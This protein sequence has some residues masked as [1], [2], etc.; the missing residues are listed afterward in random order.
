M[1]AQGPC[2]PDLFP[3]TLNCPTNLTFILQAGLCETTVQLSGVSA[4]DNCDLSVDI[5]QTGGLPINGYFPIGSH[6]V[7]LRATDDA[8]NFS[9]CTFNVVVLE[10]PYP[11][12]SLVCNTLVYLTV[13]QNGTAVVNADMVLEGGPYGCYS[14]YLVSITDAMGLD[15]GNTVTCDEIGDFLIAKV[16]DPVSGNSCWGQIVLEDKTPPIIN[17]QDWTIPCTRAVTTV[18]APGVIDNCDSNP[19]LNL[20]GVT[21][22]ETDACDDNAVRFL[23]TWYATDKF[24]NTS[25]PCLEIITVQRP[26]VVDFPSDIVWQ[27]NQYASRPN[28]TNASPLRSNIIDTIPSTEVIDV[29][30]LFIGNQLNNTGSGIP[31]NI[32]GEFCKYNI[33][34]SDD[35]IAIC[36]N[37]P[38]V[39][40][41]VRTWT[42]IDWCTGNVIIT[43]VDGEDNV[44]VIK[45][46]D[47]VPPV[48]SASNLTVNANIPG[49]HPQPCR[50]TAPFPS[51]GVTDN[52]SG[53]DSVV[54]NIPFYGKVV[55]GNIPS[56]G[57]PIGHH[58]VTIQAFDKCGNVATKDIVL[59][60][61]DGIAPTP[62]CISY[63]DVVLETNGR[64][65]VLAEAFDQASSDNCC[66][67]HF[68]VR[69]MEDSCE[70][71]HDDLLFGPSVQFC[72]EDAGKTIMVVFRAFDCFGNFNDCMVEVFVNDKLI[73]VL[74]SCPPNQRITCD[75]YADNLET[76]LTS[77]LTAAEK[78][79]Y[80]D[81]FFGAPVFYDNCQLSITRNY[82]SNIDQCLEGTI[83][84]SFTATDPSGNTSVQP[85]SQTIF[86]D[87]VSDWAVQFP[88]DITINCGT[89]PPNFG[90]P[91]IFY[92]TCE[93]VA[94]SY[95]DEL[96]TVVV[97]ACYKIVR[98]WT[99]INWCVVGTNPGLVDQEVVEQP[100]NQLGLP[101]PQCD[102]D[103]DGDCDGRTFRDS[104]RS[105]SPA[106]LNRPSALDA[107]RTT[108]PDTDLDS[109]PWDG[110]ITYQQVLKVI[111]TVDP[112]FVNGCEI[113]MVC[114]NDNTCA[115]NLLLPTPDV[116][117]CSQFVTITAKIKIGGVWLT[118]FGP[119]ANVPPGMYEVQY[120]ATD[121]CNNQTVCNSSVKVKDCK[122]PTP[123]CKTGIITT[124][125]NSIP[126]MVD[127]WASDL[128]DNSFDN[129]T[130]DLIFSFSPDTTDTSITL[131]CFN[132]NTTIFVNVW[133][134]DEC[135][136]QDFC[137]TQII[138]Q[139]NTDFC[140]DPLINLGGA[141]TTE[142]NAEI[143]DVEINLSGSTSDMAMTNGGQFNFAIPAPGG[144]YTVVP[145]KD[146][147]PLNGVTTFDLVLISKHILGVSLLDSPYKIIAADAN[148]S[149]S[150]TTFDMVEIRKLI[151]F[152]N[153]SFTNNTSWRFVDK[154]FVFPNSAN[155]W[156]TPFP[157]FFNVNDLSSD[158]LSV[159]FIGIKIGDVNGSA[160][161]N[162]L[163]G[164]NEERSNEADLLLRA[165]NVLLEK[166]Q[167]VM[168]PFHLM[169]EALGFQ[170]TLNFD[171]EKLEF[172]QMEAGLLSS[173]NFGFALLGQGAITASW[174]NLTGSSH[175]SKEEAFSLVFK[176]KEAGNLSQMLSV[177]SRFTKAE[178]YT[179]TLGTTGLSLV[180]DG[181]PNVAGYELLQ[182]IPNPFSNNTEIG[183]VLPEA[184]KCTLTIT[185]V[186]GRV[187]KVIDDNFAEGYNRIALQKTDFGTKGV[188]YYR[189]E[190]GEFTATRMMVLMD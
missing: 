59:T 109:D 175:L 184:A 183:F 14:N 71:G 185:D 43:G 168:V 188:L 143:G 166:G 152:I 186:S 25:A 144:D 58:A 189:L 72:C 49:V 180:F 115:V 1:S 46:V 104:W 64:A 190:T 96:F 100:E 173:E 142:G 91:T 60:V 127:V 35:T 141:V 179:P 53:V 122:K 178:A 69:R 158:L 24:G 108:G 187:L 34:H 106:N 163:T 132:Q 165:N 147:S 167:T 57:P 30:P 171:K 113:P 99:V 70:D 29:N 5:S 56:P 159:D 85:C 76:Q 146:D 156:Q 94:I 37:V 123:Y 160:Q 8:G 97:D 7:T 52:C 42:V 150:V 137:S 128:D 130:T 27:C 101:F 88:A 36:V 80:L 124:L 148:K 47:S 21:P 16:M 48:I 170:F 119:Y 107:T 62:I 154:G 51:P 177:D 17:C 129:C 139:D 90:E 54:I 134:T 20:A 98:T 95:D 55:N 149:G 135:G 32:T 13:Q 103:G 112:V 125:M 87:H 61:I 86:V 102:I 121:N 138:I 114:I 84:R 39:F 145:L 15:Y 18:A 117:D 63:T 118:G 111:D 26:I 133:V 22:I 67:D 33:T 93:L 176:V 92:E 65:E 2:T 31:A 164:H 126:P 38:G 157:E 73:P 174:N 83:T 11:T 74:V 140:G 78:S 19:S 182:N 110:Y 6:P 3:P 81:Q 12:Q 40:K 161:A 10:F 105:G 153:D 68:E 66:L 131:F 89:T 50:S 151:L 169:G 116:L 82:T 23:R 41:I 120:T 79:Q 181:T 172:V 77:L 155:P 28:I 162:N 136:N 75:W 4:T 45:V 44:Q 9:N